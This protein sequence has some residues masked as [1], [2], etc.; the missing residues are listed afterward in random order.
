MLLEYFV[1]RFAQKM[2]KHFGKID[3]RTVELFAPI[4][5]RAIFRE[6]QNVVERSS[7]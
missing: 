1:N 2:G 4:P 5:G 3:K 6:L 7:S